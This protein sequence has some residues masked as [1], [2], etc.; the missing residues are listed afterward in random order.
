MTNILTHTTK[1]YTEEVIRDMNAFEVGKREA[2][3]RG[4]EIWQKVE[5]ELMEKLHVKR[6]AFFN[7]ISGGVVHTEFERE[8]IERVFRSYG[9]TEIWGK[10]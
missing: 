2:I 10:A 6:R 7:R 4:G 8:G 3:A 5:A 9:I 1:N